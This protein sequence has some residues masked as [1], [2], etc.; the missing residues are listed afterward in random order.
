[1][2]GKVAAFLAALASFASAARAAELPSAAWKYA[3][4]FCGVI[5]SMAPIAGGTQYALVLYASHGTTLDAHV[6]AVSAKDAYD[7][8]VGAANLSGPPEDRR[9]DPV[10]VSFS[11]GAEPQYFFVDSYTL[12][13]GAGV[14]CPSYVFELDD[15]VE[16]SPSVP[17]I[18]AQ[19]VQALGKLQCAKMYEAPGTGKGMESFLGQYGNRPL[20]VEILVSIDSNGQAVDEQVLHSS[21][22]DGV[23]KAAAGIISIHR[24]VPARFLCTP[25]VGT[26]R[27][28]LEYDP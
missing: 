24:F 2:L 11:D 3:N 6:T 15:P 10:V 16:G 17:P 22:V 18:F 5:A 28:Q 7:I 26:M 14:T 25:V 12:D 23:D 1:M 13:R 9:S 19:H 8:H 20:T 4:P 27:L 21:G